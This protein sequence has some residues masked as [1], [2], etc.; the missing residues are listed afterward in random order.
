MSSMTKPK[1]NLWN[2][3]NGSIQDH[4][5]LFVWSLVF[6]DV[7]LVISFNELEKNKHEILTLL[8]LLLLKSAWPSMRSNTDGRIIKVKGNVLTIEFVELLVKFEN[9]LKTTLP[10]CIYCF[11]TD[12]IEKVLYLSSTI[13]VPCSDAFY[14]QGLL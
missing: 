5:I 4:K 2:L 7:V 11:W 13:Q 10:A 6:N 1:P 12:T 3:V 14:F 8:W 9:A